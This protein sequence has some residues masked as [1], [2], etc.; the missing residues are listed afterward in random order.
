MVAIVEWEDMALQEVS[1]EA[2]DME[3]VMVDMEEA[4]VVMEALIFDLVQLY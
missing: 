2:E 3:A 1:M 4:W